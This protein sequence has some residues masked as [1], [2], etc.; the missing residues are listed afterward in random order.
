MGNWFFYSHFAY[1]PNFGGRAFGIAIIGSIPRWH[2]IR[3]LQS[4]P[5][6]SDNV[7]KIYGLHKAINTL[8]SETQFIIEGRSIFTEHIIGYVWIDRKFSGS[9]LQ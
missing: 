2:C 6:E 1:S 3:A 5:G 8:C 4:A 9:V 7:S